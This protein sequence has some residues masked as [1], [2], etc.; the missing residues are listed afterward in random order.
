VRS[1]LRDALDFVERLQHFGEVNTAWDAFI[2][3]TSHFGFTSGALADMPGPGER[4]ED[5]V[6]GR[7]HGATA[8]S[9]EITFG[10]T[11]PGCI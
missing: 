11:L 2:D 9:N 3:Y 4:L 6:H 8:I 10:M 7:R 5:T 1:T